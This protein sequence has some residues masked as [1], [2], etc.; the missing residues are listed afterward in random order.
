MGSGSGGDG[1]AAEAAESLR[2]LVEEWLDSLSAFDV[3]ALVVLGPA[4]PD[5]PMRRE[6]WAAHPFDL[7]PAA[8]AF[9][10]SDAYGPAWRAS[11]SPTMAWQNL[12][13]GSGTGWSSY[14]RE[15][16][17]LALVRSDFPMPFGAGFECVAFVGRHL[18]ARAE[19]FEIGWALNNCWPGIRDAVIA[20]RFGLTPRTRE[21]LRVLAE[22]RTAKETAEIVSCKERTVHFHLSTV[23]NRL[24]ADNR[25]AA[26]LRACML[27]IL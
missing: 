16:G 19:A 8:E 3:R 2:E 21:V 18:V 23:M 20:S 1:N 26:I 10:R 24:N 13:E 6:V 7:Q 5:E 25:A 9:A 17:V 4:S 12:P 14:L 27:G 22:G 15:E 11:Q